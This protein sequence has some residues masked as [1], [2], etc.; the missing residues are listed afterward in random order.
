MLRRLK[1]AFHLEISAVDGH[2]GRVHDFLFDDESWKV[3]YFVVDVSRW[4]PGR[5]VLLSPHVAGPIDW[6]NHTI[7]VKLTR[8]EVRDSPD[9]STD[10]P[11]AFQHLAPIHAYYGWPF[12]EGMDVLAASLAQP[13]DA[14]KDPHLRSVR[15]LRGYDISET[16]GEFGHLVDFIFEDLDWQIRYL[17]VET[18]K[19][20]HRRFVLIPPEWAV[21]I[22]WVSRHIKLE[23]TS[24]QIKNSPAVNPDSP[25]DVQTEGRI[26]SYFG[27]PWDASHA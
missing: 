4:F 21:G 9:I 26:S 5:R 17:V 12:W 27:H 8:A 22:D 3:R 18:K 19:W 2:L 25:L 7:P 23:L 13:K 15:E 16:D 1:Y 10:Q 14:P 11:V 24:D 6:D 20:F